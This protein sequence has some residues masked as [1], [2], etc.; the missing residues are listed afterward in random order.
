METLSF[1]QR[2]PWGPSNNDYNQSPMTAGT[3]HISCPVLPILRGDLRWHTCCTPL[4][5]RLSLWWEPPGRLPFVS[6]IEWVHWSPSGSSG[7]LMLPSTSESSHSIP[8]VKGPKRCFC[9]LQ[10]LWSGCKSHM[11]SSQ[12]PP[13]QPQL[14]NTSV[15][16]TLFSFHLQL[17]AGT[18]PT[19]F[20]HEI[21][22]VA[23]YA[24]G[25]GGSQKVGLF[26][27]T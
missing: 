17:W 13:N 20:C 9:F 22:L 6:H 21:S 15:R 5:L 8:L 4:L 27:L 19:L 23:S 11:F 7:L 12:L 14:M 26:S 1:A 2:T 10:P 24:C 3:D 18:Q 25:E 16:C